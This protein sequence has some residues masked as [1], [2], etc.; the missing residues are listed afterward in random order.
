[1][2]DAISEAA[3]DAECDVETS[4]ERLFRGYRLQRTRRRRSRSPPRRSAPA[5]IEPAYINTGGGSDANALIAAGLPVLNVANGTERNHQPDESVTVDA[6]ETMLDVTLAIVAASAAAPM[7]FERVGERDR[8]GGAIATVR[9]DRFRYDDGEEAEREIVAHPGAVAVVAHDG[10]RLYLVRQP[11]EAVGEQ[12]LLELPAGKLDEDGEEPLDT[13]KR[14]LAE[15]IGK[16]AR[17]LGA[18]DELLHLAGLRRRGVPR[19]PR[20]RPLRR[21]R[22]GRRGR[23]H[24]DRRG[25]AGRARR[26]DRATAATRNR[27]SACSGSGL[28][29]RLTPLVAA[30]RDGRRADEPRGDGHDRAAARRA[31]RFEHLVLDFLAYLE[32]ER[33]LSRNTLEAYRADLLQFGRFLARRATV[34]ARRDARDVS[35][36][37]TELADRRRRH[38]PPR[39]P[40]STAS[41]PACAPS[42]ATCAA[43]AC[44]TPTRPPTLSPPRRS[45]KLPQVLT[46]GEVEKLLSQPSGTEPA[47]LRDRALLELMYACGLR[48]SEAIGLELGDVDLEDRVLRARGKGSKERIVPIGRRRCGRCAST[49]SA[50]ARRW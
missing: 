13:A 18:P 8:L 42:T 1:M 2:V 21:E 5:D 44:A 22:R 38:R 41:P 17:T 7:A 47:A 29:A 46:R 36:F 10:E 4:V 39:R 19:L 15:E 27:W 9:V 26:R 31:R 28:P 24:R 6:L 20:H 30:S 49:S 48:A 33:G 45:R 11:R 43:R 3:S 23:A 14:E 32:F 16:G 37:L 50:A 35:D 34:G 12:A 25:A 40:R